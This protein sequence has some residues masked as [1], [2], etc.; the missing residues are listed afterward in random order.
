MTLLIV[1]VHF[2]CF[3]S[4]FCLRFSS[5]KQTV[6]LRN[7][8][9]KNSSVMSHDHQSLFCSHIILSSSVVINV[10]CG[11]VAMLFPFVGSDSEVVPER[12]ENGNI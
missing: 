12:M 6:K 10:S 2:L 3:C 5:L 8:K 7:N 1:F 9:K 11:V 4:V